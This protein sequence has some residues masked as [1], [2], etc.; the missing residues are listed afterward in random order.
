[1]AD[2][3]GGQRG[4]SKEAKREREGGKKAGHAGN[5]DWVS[6][7]ASWH[8]ARKRQCEKPGAGC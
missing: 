2:A 4:R 3:F 7:P 6:R 5:H 1:M 8:P